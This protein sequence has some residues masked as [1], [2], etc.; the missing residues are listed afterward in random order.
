MGHGPFHLAF[1][2]Y[3][4]GDWHGVR[5][6]I[7][8]I[9]WEVIFNQGAFPVIIEFCEWFQLG[10]HVFNPYRKYQFKPH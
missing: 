10:T 7:R 5:D 4:C 8:D 9:P 6:H 3:S 1:F 2:D